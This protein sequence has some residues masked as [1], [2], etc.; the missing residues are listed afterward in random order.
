MHPTVSKLIEDHRPEIER[1]CEACDVL[2]LSLFGSAVDGRFRP[3]ESDLDFVVRYRKGHDLRGFDYLF[4]LKHGL[5]RLLGYSVDVID[6]D[7]IEGKG[8]RTL[9]L[10]PRER[11][12]G[13]RT[14]APAE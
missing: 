5:E 11:V 13:G 9:V 2:E 1:L 10:E 8:R 12:Y 7:V 3:A 6:E 4:K 14:P